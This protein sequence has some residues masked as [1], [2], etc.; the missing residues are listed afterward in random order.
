[1]VNKHTWEPQNWKMGTVRVMKFTNGRQYHS[2]LCNLG[3]FE[4]HLGRGDDDDGDGDEEG[5]G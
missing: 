1:M 5:G 2:E 4:E 3:L